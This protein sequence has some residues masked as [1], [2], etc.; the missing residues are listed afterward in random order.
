MISESVKNDPGAAVMRG[1]SRLA[2]RLKG[3]D[4]L[5]DLYRKSAENGPEGFFGRVFSGLNLEIDDRAWDARLPLSG[6]LLVMASG[7]VDAA[8]ALGL[9]AALERKRPDAAALATRALGW[10]P[11]ARARMMLIQ[12]GPGTAQVNAAQL[13]LALRHLRAGGALVCFPWPGGARLKTPRPGQDAGGRIA[14]W[15]ASA[16]GAE[17]LP[18]HLFRKSALPDRIV[19]AAGSPLKPSRLREYPGRDALADYL[20]L[21]ACLLRERETLLPRRASRA[22]A[23]LASA[24]P[25]ELLEEELARMSP[26]Q[27]LGTSGALEVWTAQAYEIPMLLREI[28]RL[29]E[30]SFRVAG[31]GTGKP[32]DLDRYDQHYRQLFVWD[33]EARRLVGGYRMGCTDLI[34][35][36]YGPDGLYTHSLLRMK[37]SLLDNFS[38]ALELGRSFVRPEYQ[39]SY[40]P[41][42]LL[43]KGIGAFV[44][45]YPRYHRLFGMVSISDDYHPLSKELMIS[46]VKQRLYRGDLAR[47]ARPRSPYSP[48]YAERPVDDLTWRL[49]ADIEEV[50]D[51]VTELEQDGKGV[52]V[53]LKQYARL[54]ATFFGFN[55]DAE[56]GHVVDGILVVD[57]LA[58]EP[59]VLR[60]YLGVEGMK[61]F[62]AWH[63]ASEAVGAPI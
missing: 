51:W 4:G 19:L 48:G 47:L 40:A 43:W 5:S 7:P 13:R 42:M 3:L 11:E 59:S 33:R 49:G 62:T 56:F 2:G 31:E 61:N 24:V 16:S 28:G 32:L 63:A 1:L 9:M 36:A 41:L 25:P 54:G 12:A 60:R 37:K 18:V 39:R 46:F 23:P 14:A 17:V 50:S 29:R 44:A 35:K 52:P 38:P 55:V 8:A 27:K 53:L 26:M 6:P 58:A 30:A 15:L 34:L 22:S 21:R 45:R 20:R 10:A 57:L